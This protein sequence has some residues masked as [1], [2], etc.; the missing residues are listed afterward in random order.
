[1]SFIVRSPSAFPFPKKNT[2]FVLF[3]AFFAPRDC[4]FAG[5]LT[6]VTS[7]EL[8]AADREADF[9]TV[10]LRASFFAIRMPTPFEG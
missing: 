10:D 1:M 6:V 8:R 5:R 3:D 9:F 2:C 7:L 4:R